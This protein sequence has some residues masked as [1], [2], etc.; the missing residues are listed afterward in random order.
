MKKL[1][2]IGWFFLACGSS[3]SPRTQVGPFMDKKTCEESR[4]EYMSGAI[5]NSISCWQS[6]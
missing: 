3:D 4:K 1:I 5:R 6:S 2:L